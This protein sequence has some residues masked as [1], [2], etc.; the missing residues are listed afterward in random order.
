MTGPPG[1]QTPHYVL[2]SAAFGHRTRTV[3]IG[4]FRHALRWKP[5]PEAGQYMPK[6]RAVVSERHDRWL[7]PTP[8]PQRNSPIAERH[9]GQDDE[10]LERGSDLRMGIGVRDR[11]FS[12][13]S[14]PQD[15]W[16]RHHSLPSGSRRTWKD[17]A[18]S[19]WL[20]PTRWAPRTSA[21]RVAAAMSD[22]PTS[23]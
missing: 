17:P 22:T 23:R 6:R 18:V 13:G 11:P 10:L 8:V 16:T 14:L 15:G 7:T 21:C 12:P 20:P 5:Q 4:L 3:T 9:A 19:P 1:W 2:A